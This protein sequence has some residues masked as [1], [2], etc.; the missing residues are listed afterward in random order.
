MKP[1]VVNGIQKAGTKVFTNM[2]DLTAY[3]NAKG[4]K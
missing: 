1:S 3:I 4:A 2:E